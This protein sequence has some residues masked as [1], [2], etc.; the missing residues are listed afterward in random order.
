MTCKCQY[1]GLR[2]R[3]NN[4]P[5]AL[6]RNLARPQRS[7]PSLPFAV[8]Q[9]TIVY[10]GSV[11]LPSCARVIPTCAISANS[12]AWL[13]KSTV[14]S[15]TATASTCT[16]LRSDEGSAAAEAPYYLQAWAVLGLCRVE[17]SAQI[18]AV[19][20]EGWAFADHERSAAG[21]GTAVEP[22]SG[23][24]WDGAKPSHAAEVH[25]RAAASIRTVPAPLQSVEA[26][27]QP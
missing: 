17:R 26:R 5:A 3:V 12:G 15:R 20:R 11:D 14:Y 24:A 27:G 7:P 10:S 19:G 2:C 23:L 21:A 6:V 25:G 16:G 22:G 4:H 1:S 13:S 18:C 9:V 8:V